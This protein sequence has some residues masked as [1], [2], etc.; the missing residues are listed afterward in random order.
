MPSILRQYS[1]GSSPS[2]SRDSKT[3]N[4]SSVI[5]AVAFSS[6]STAPSSVSSG[7]PRIPA[8]CIPAPTGN[9]PAYSETARPWTAQRSTFQPSHQAYQ[10]D[11]SPS[12]LCYPRSSVDTYVSDSESE[13]DDENAIDDT[14]DITDDD[15][16][17]SDSH[18]NYLHSASA[19]HKASLDDNV[20][21][22][23][24]DYRPDVCGGISSM[25]YSTT[26]Q[27]F[28]KL[29]PSLNR[30]S[31]R[32]DETTADGNMNLRVDIAVPVGERRRLTSYQLF[33]LRM[34]DLAKREFSLRRY[35]RDSGREVCNSKLN[36]IDPAD[37]T[38]KEK[39]SRSKMSIISRKSNEDDDDDED[40]KGFAKHWARSSNS[41]HS[42]KTAPSIDLRP[43]LQRSMTTALRSLGAMA[44]VRPSFRRSASSSSQ[45]KYKSQ[46]SRPATSHYSPYTPAST[47]PTSSSPPALS[48]STPSFF[49]R[50]KGRL[51][52]PPPAPKPTNTV[53]L[54]FSNYARVDL[55]RSSTTGHHSHSHNQT[56][57]N[58]RYEFEWWGHKYTWKRSTDKLLN[59]VS[60]HLM[61]D[62]NGEIPIAHIVPEMRSPNQ[63]DADEDAGGWIPPCHLWI[64]DPAV[65]NAMTDVADVLV[66]TGLLALTDDCIRTRWPSKASTTS[67][68]SG[69]AFDMEHVG[70]RALMQHV[71]HRR[72]SNS[73]G[74]TTHASPYMSSPLR[75]AEPVY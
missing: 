28:A 45:D 18:K 40:D 38:K 61:R 17:I 55:E 4:S 9:P 32:H 44:S 54:E 15:D 41:S 24:P 70:P 21:P 33:H 51:S 14:F 36:F 56:S 13:E 64:S 63:V 43:T 22:P 42:V 46:S 5:D 34:Y 50:D 25:H 30:M 75:H 8:K 74:H 12:T 65:L 53:K 49:S 11:L 59:T 31:I 48:S 20:I 67:N 16:Y 10:D 60:Y 68:G 57:D 66:A 73:S 71:F 6:Q 35:G 7:S 58:T 27:E 2:S 62:D 37:K 47:S 39:K 52:P 26:P 3:Q 1:G 69:F 29:F 19:G 23:L 72:G